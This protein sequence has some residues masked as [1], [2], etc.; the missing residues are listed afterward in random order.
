MGTGGG[1]PDRD[2]HLRLGDPRQRRWGQR[3]SP[4]HDA[5]LDNVA[6]TDNQPVADAFLDRPDHHVPVDGYHGT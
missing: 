5:V 4:H 3:T 6:V 1:D 2:D